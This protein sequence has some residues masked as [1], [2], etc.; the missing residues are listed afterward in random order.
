MAATP[1]D[2]RDLAGR[3][4]HGGKW[5]VG[6]ASRGVILPTCVRERRLC[7]PL[8][9]PDQPA[10][11]GPRLKPYNVDL[12][13]DAVGVIQKEAR[14]LL[15]PFKQLMGEIVLEAAARIERDRS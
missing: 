9:V 2:F 14:R 8:K 5:Q 13:M 7:V 11:R 3:P 1:A 4:S 15:I 10:D 12:P 6:A